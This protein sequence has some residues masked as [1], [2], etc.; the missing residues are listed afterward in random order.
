MIDNTVSTAMVDNPERFSVIMVEIPSRTNQSKTTSILNNILAGNRSDHQDPARFSDIYAF[1]DWSLGA[2][3]QIIHNTVV[4]AGH[5][6]VVGENTEATVSNNIV[7][8]HAVG[9]G[10]LGSGSVGVTRNLFWQVR[11]TEY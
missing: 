5:G 9:I 4:S 3:V 10:T 2:R 11:M 7:S 8:G 6:I 1:G